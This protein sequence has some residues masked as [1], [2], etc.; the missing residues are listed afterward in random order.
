MSNQL[1]KVKELI[2]LREQA[3]LGGGEKRIESQHKKGKLPLVSVSP[4]CL[5]KV[6]SRNSTCL[7][8]TVVQTSVSRKLN[9]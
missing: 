3:R 4:C 1:E 9:I 2:A 7:F 8:N 6:V 5:T